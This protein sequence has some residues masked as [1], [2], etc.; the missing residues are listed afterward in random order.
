MLYRPSF[1]TP[2]TAVLQEQQYA[3][4]AA[5]KNCVVQTSN[6]CVNFG[7][8]DAVPT[9]ETTTYHRYVNHSRAWMSSFPFLFDR[10]CATNISVLR[11]PWSYYT[12]VHAGGRNSPMLTTLVKFLHSYTLAL[13]KFLHSVPALG[14]KELEHTQYTVSKWEMTPEFD[15]EKWTQQCKLHANCS[16]LAKASDE[17]SVG[18]HIL[19]SNQSLTWFDHNQHDYIP[20][21]SYKCVHATVC[22]T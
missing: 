7:D 18:V 12:Q 13:P 8:Y 17:V 10:S 1:K 6:F 21:H 15:A 11:S 9:R 22:S 3:R 14:F 5:D 16:Q 20:C 4:E 2:E 19:L